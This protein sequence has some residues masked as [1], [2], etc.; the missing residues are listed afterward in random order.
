MEL[1]NLLIDTIPYIE[2]LEL[3]EFKSILLGDSDTTVKE[4]NGL[5]ILS[6]KKIIKCISKYYTLIDDTK[7][8]DI[9]K[10]NFC[11]YNHL[12][13]GIHCNV[14]NCAECHLQSLKLLKQGQLKIKK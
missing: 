12:T 3:D 10:T 7:L 8:Q 14:Y 5:L 9:S 11:Y 6:N 13:A 1:L 4:K 2:G